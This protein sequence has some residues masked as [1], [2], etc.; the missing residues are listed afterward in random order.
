MDL[1]SSSGEDR[2]TPIL[3]YLLA[4]AVLDLPSARGSQL[5]G[6]FPPF[7]ELRSF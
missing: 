4:G 6:F 3:L 1:S 5:M 2:K 7:T